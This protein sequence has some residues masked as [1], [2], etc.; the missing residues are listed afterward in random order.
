MQ[1]LEGAGFQLTGLSS[2]AVTGT[3]V[4]VIHRRLR[5]KAVTDVH[6][7]VHR[8]LEKAHLPIW[9]SPF[10]RS[11][12][13]VSKQ[14]TS[15]TCIVRQYTGHRVSGNLAHQHRAVVDAH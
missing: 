7:K 10:I 4:E 2:K 6:P 9:W 8:G 14:A 1:I 15:S 3:R 13:N 12:S 5:S 11:P